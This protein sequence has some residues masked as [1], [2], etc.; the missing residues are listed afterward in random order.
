[1]G[2]DNSRNVEGLGRGGKSDAV[3]LRFLADACKRYVLVTEERHVAV[4]LVRYHKDPVPEADVCKFGKS[5][6][7]P[8]NAGRVVRIA[9][10]KHFASFVLLKNPVQ[11]FQVHGIST[12]GLFNQGVEY[13]LVAAILGNEPERVVYGR[14]DDNFVTGLQHCTD[15]HP[16]SFDYSGDKVYPLFTDVPAVAVFLPFYDGGGEVVR[17]YGVAEDGMFKAFAECIDDKI[18][19]LELHVRHPHW[20]K[21]LASEDSVHPFVFVGACASS[22]YRFVKVVHIYSL[23]LSSEMGPLAI[24][25][26]SL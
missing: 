14:L 22:V 9:K 6:L 17:G 1:M 12:I 8:D 4:N 11:A 2:A 18:R 26:P 21:V 23:F 25:S 13:D 15:G 5:L 19:G 20:L 7:V 3:L 24:T 16:Y 10:D